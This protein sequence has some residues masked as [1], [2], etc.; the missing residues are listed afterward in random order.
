M[1][2]LAGH[3][4]G[5]ER[6]YFLKDDTSSGYLTFNEFKLVFQ[7]LQS[8][9]LAGQ[10]LDILGLDSCL[11][12]MAEVCY[13]LRTLVNTVVGCESYAPA[14]GW[15]YRSILE[16]LKSIVEMD[17]A[18]QDVPKSFAKGIVEDYVSSYADYAEGGLSVTQSALDVTEVDGLTEVIRNFAKTVGSELT[19]E[20]KQEYARPENAPKMFPLRDALILA[21]WEAQSYNGEWYVDVA[22]FCDCL[23]KRFPDGDVAG[24]CNKVIDFITEKFVLR[25]CFSGPVYQYSNG[26][27]IYFPW[28]TVA[29][30]YS[31]IDFAAGAG[32][33][34]FLAVYTDLT[35]REPRPPADEKLETFKA[36]LEVRKINGM[37]STQELKISA[38]R[39]GSGRMGSGRMGSGRMGSGR[40][41]SGRMGSGRMGSGRMGSGK[42][43]SGREGNPIHSMRNPPIVPPP[44]D[45]ESH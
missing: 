8:E 26:V 7:T 15:P 28:S 34:D 29:P 1:V 44:F 23:R 33:A 22:D 42:M 18:Y 11:M 45:C 25:S 31:N 16:R 35:R 37:L 6:D 9:D 30:F 12:S 14:A 41:G 38:G 5:T 36:F 39:M 21:H 40:M 4:A 2:V 10:P 13:E 3:G 27:S 20:H 17:E 32:W 24:A 19:E 43:G